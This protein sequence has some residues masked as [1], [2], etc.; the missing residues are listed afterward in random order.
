M[1]VKLL[2]A[3]WIGAAI[4]VLLA[5]LY[6]YND[7]DLSDIWVFLTWLMLIL[8]FPAGVLISIAHFVIGEVFATT[9]KTS[10]ISLSVEW[11][12]YFLLGYI[13]WFVLLPRLW[14]RWKARR[15]G[16]D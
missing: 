13:Q 3:L 2:K 8:S 5:T 10:F 6:F 11:V 15:A 12:A 1:F 9:V 7:E 16:I 4:F 14:H